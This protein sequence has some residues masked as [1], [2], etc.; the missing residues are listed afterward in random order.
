MSRGALQDFRSYGGISAFIANQACTDRSQ[1]SVRITANGVC[2]L[3]GMALG[4]KA[5]T[6]FPRQGSLYRFP[7]KQGHQGNMG[8]DIEVFFT[9]KSTT[10]GN[11]LNYNSVFVEI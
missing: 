4:M 7:R 11:E 3:Y 8:L 5:D 10:V 1:F 2:H 6:F 9:A